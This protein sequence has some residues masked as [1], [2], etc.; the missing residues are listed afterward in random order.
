MAEWEDS[1]DW[2]PNKYRHWI[3]SIEKYVLLGGGDDNQ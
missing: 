1:F 2:E 3:K